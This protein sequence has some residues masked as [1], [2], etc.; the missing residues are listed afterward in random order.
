MKRR[1]SIFNVLGA[2]CVIALLAMLYWSSLLIETDFKALQKE[3]DDLRR[4][5]ETIK[6]DLSLSSSDRSI[7]SISLKEPTKNLA[8]ERFPNLLKTDPFYAHTLSQLVGR[9]F[10]PNGE[11]RETILGRPQDLHPFNSF[12]DVS[13]LVNMCVGS[14]GTLQIG[15]Y[16]AFAPQL[17]WKVEVRPAIE[18]GPLC[19]YWVHLREGLK[20]APLYHKGLP[21][22]LEIAPQFFES[23]PVTAHDFK[24]FFDAIMNPYVSNP[25]AAALKTYYKDINSLRVIDDLTFVVQWK[26]KEVG[27]KKERRMPY[28][29]LSTTVF[30]Q[31]LPRHIYQYFA[32]GRKIV[33]EDGAEDCY[34][35]N[36]IWAQNFSHHWAKNVIPSCS[37]WTFYE[38]NEEGIRLLR[39]P[40]Y[41]NPLAALVAE[42]D[43]VFKES[44]EAMWQ[45]FKAGHSDL[46]TMTPNQLPELDRFL[47]S[48]LYESQAKNGKAVHHLEYLDQAYNYIGW[49]ESREF[50]KN[51]AVR[52]A[53]TLAIDR[54]RI[55]QQNLGGMGD[56]LTGP[57]HKDSPSY[58]SSINPLPFSPYEAKRILDEE[59]WVDLDGD[60]IRD[61]II[62]GEK[63]PFRFSLTYYIKNIQSKV[64]CE[65]VSTVLKEIGVDCQLKG[66][67]VADLSHAFDEKK[68][69]AL[70][71]GW[72]LGVPP[73]NPRQLWHSS[74]AKEKGSSNAIGFANAEI[75]AIIETLDFEYDKEKRIALYHRFHQLIHELQPY[76]FLY[77]PKRKLIYRD[78]VKNV[79]IPK[80]RQDLIPGADISEPDGRIFWVTERT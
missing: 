43:Y 79:F 27:S 52:K 36:V 50:F 17:A 76:T 31:P 21:Q 71:M 33:E 54:K 46:C 7:S 44:F 53:M 67:D 18:G 45:D 57:F 10:V 14:V 37:A 75:D 41:F 39:N 65:Y 19:E 73:E 66:V 72:A 64:I 40:H 51:A 2:G 12:K 60:G 24:F 62:N 80:D 11:R 30:L 34:R 68:F 4:Q 55:I 25:K 69:D 15:K 22:E 28:S 38:M 1:L 70:F 3:L 5:T 63:V 29:S 48:P 56:L 8:E 23:H 47:K 59:G 49:N 20:W 58:D 9:H 35:N 78:Y 16:E 32:D 74:G 26:T 42:T 61:K 77:I 13:S 6:K